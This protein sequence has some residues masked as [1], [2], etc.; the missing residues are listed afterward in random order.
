MLFPALPLSVLVLLPLPFLGGGGDKVGTVKSVKTVVVA[1]MED[2]GGGEGGGA[3]S[4][5]ARVVGDNDPKREVEPQL[6]WRV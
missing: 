6:T 5:G 3:T 1:G 4:G 2:C